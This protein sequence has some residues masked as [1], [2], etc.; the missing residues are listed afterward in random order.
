MAPG[1][2]A[3]RT[4]QSLD[5][6][7]YQQRPHESCR[8]AFDEWDGT[9]HRVLNCLVCC[10]GQTGGET[11]HIVTVSCYQ[12]VRVWGWRSGTLL[13]ILRDKDPCFRIDVVTHVMAT[14]LLLAGTRIYGRALPRNRRE[15]KDADS[16]SDGVYKL[17]PKHRFGSEVMSWSWM[18]NAPSAKHCLLHTF[19]HTPRFPEP[20]HAHAANE[21]RRWFKHVLPAV[22]C[23]TVMDIDAEAFVWAHACK[24]IEVNEGRCGS[25]ATCFQNL[26]ARSAPLK[27]FAPRHGS[28]F[29]EHLRWMPKSSFLVAGLADSQGRGSISIYRFGGGELILHARASLDRDAE[30]LPMYLDTSGRWISDRSK[31]LITSL[32]GLRHTADEKVLFAAAPAT[33]E[34]TQKERP[35]HNYGFADRE[36]FAHCFE[37]RTSSAS[38]EGLAQLAA[39]SRSVR[40]AGYQ[41]LGEERLLDKGVV[42][43]FCRRN[44]EAERLKSKYGQDDHVDWYERLKEEEAMERQFHGPRWRTLSS[45]QKPAEWTTVHARGFFADWTKPCIHER[46]GRRSDP[47]G[48]DWH[49][50]RWYMPADCR[51]LAAEDPLNT[52]RIFQLCAATGL[53]LRIADFSCGGVPH[54]LLLQGFDYQMEDELFIC[55]ATVHQNPFALPGVDDGHDHVRTTVDIAGVPVGNIERPWRLCAPLL[56]LPA[57]DAELTYLV[58]GAQFVHDKFG[59]GVVWVT[60]V[61]QFV[62]LGVLKVCAFC[63]CPGLFWRLGPWLCIASSHV[64]L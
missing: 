2:S 6:I 13:A 12:A 61:L 45:L 40:A 50:E 48:F 57:A 37:G 47:S 41:R 20:S 42:S 60:W 36:S 4:A 55:G 29:C 31:T 24:A 46:L 15:E 63:L 3:R 49:S 30:I 19:G 21:R 32:I 9:D 11:A 18:D 10:G 14:T 23:C 62:I 17:F 34:K 28:T 43:H 44:W 33:E 53:V 64:F 51:G 56:R 22:R 58:I 16:D 52:M 35:A 5:D 1:P 38:G 59:H 39:I 27:Q 26:A 7:G 25:N 8:F 54:R